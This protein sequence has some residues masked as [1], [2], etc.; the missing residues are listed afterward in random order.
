MVK[1]TMIVIGKMFA[2]INKKQN[3]FKLVLV[4][5]MLKRGAPHAQAEGCLNYQ[6][7]NNN[8]NAASTDG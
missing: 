5:A 8:L 7:C 2:I 4:V 6:L 1:A 3:K